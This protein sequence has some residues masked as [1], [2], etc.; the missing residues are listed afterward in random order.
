[1]RYLTAGTV[2]AQ[3]VFLLLLKLIILYPGFDRAD[4]WTAKLLPVDVVHLLVQFEET[5]RSMGWAVPAALSAFLGIRSVN[6]RK[7]ILFSILCQ[8][9]NGPFCH[10]F[11]LALR[12]EIIIAPRSSFRRKLQTLWFWLPATLYFLWSR[13]ND[14]VFILDIILKCGYRNLWGI[15]V[16]YFKWG[17]M[18]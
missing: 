9:D 13:Q 12:K 14:C 11:I 5:W 16:R 6:V 3:A 1:M 18:A 15:I 7:N 2:V 10:S 17:I 4:M 8:W